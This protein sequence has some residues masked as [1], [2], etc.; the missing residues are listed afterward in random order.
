MRLLLSGNE[1]VAEGSAAAGVFC[2]TGYPGTPATET[3]EAASKHKDIY[4]EWSVNEK[5]ALEFASGISLSGRRAM[6]VM[7]HVGLNVASDP[8]MSLAYTGVNAGLVIVVSD[9]PDMKSSQNAQ[10]SRFFGKYAGIPVLEPSDGRE[11]YELARAA[12]DISEDFDTPVIVRL[13]AVLSHSRSVV[14]L[15]DEKH[16][17]VPKEYGRDIKKNV[18]LPPLCFDKNRGLKQRLKRLREFAGTFGHN[19]TEYGPDDIGVVTSGIAYQYVKEALPDASVLK[20]A[21]VYPLNRDAVEEFRSRC[22]RLFVIEENEP[23]IETEMRL[24]GFTPAGRLD[25]R[26]TVDGELSVK[27]VREIIEGTSVEYASPSSREPMPVL[28][29]GCPYRGIF[30]L[31]SESDCFVGGD[32]GCYTLSC[33]T[34]PNSMDSVLCMGSGISQAA[35]FSRAGGKKA[36]AVIGDSTFYHAGIPAVINAVYHNAD[37]LIIVLDNRTT[38]MTGGQPHA[39]SGRGI[40]GEKRDFKIEDVMRSIGVRRVSRVDAFSLGEMRKVFTDAIGFK[41]V[42]GIIIDGRCVLQ[43]KKKNVFYIDKEVCVECRECLKIR[44]GAIDSYTIDRSCT[45]CGICMEVC[46]AGAVKK[47]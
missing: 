21:L 12:F 24:M 39:G 20:P 4:V 37:I 7:K 11:C 1:A 34:F 42:N 19:K 10:D 9:D 45:G 38:A 2:V 16:N 47:R 44:C 17:P 14:E 28:C 3:V 30:Y 41:G 25:G 6:V 23:F 31:I 43:T 13:T 26:I 36:I 27:H 5:T 35:G 18:L 8:L 29:P 40:R 46:E 32:I 15:P 33:L 22:K